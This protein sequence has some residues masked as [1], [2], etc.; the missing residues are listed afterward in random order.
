MHEV[1]VEPVK[2]TEIGAQVAVPSVI[3]IVLSGTPKERND[4]LTVE[5]TI[6]V[7]LTLREGVKAAAVV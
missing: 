7:T 4:T 2:D 3:C 5:R 6:A 1:G